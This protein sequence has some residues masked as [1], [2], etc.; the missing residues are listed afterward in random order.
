M[1]SALLMELSVVI[2]NGN[3]LFVLLDNDM[4]IV[5]PVY[6]F[7]KF[8]KQKDK[9]I[10]TIKAN[11]S[12]LKIYW[13]FLNKNGY[14]FNEVTPSTV[15]DFIEYLRESDDSE[16]VVALHKE[17][18][19]T[20]KTINRILSTVYSFYKYCGMMQEINNPI[21][22]EEINRPFNM[23][24]SL[25]H[26]ARNDN[27]IKQS[28]FKVKESKH[29]VRLVCDHEAETFLNALPTWR[30]KLIFKVLY[31]TGARI[32]E[33]LDLQIEIIPYPDSSKQLGMLEN[34]KSKGKRRNLYIPMAL[35][36]EL[37]KFIV[38]KRSNI[39]TEHSYIFVAQQKQNLGKPLTYRGIYEVF[40][41][42]KRKTGI[43]FN[44]HDLRHTYITH[45]VENG[46]DISV[47]RIIAGHEN[48][49]TTQQYTHISDKYLE[50]SLSKYWQSSS[51][52]GGNY[53]EE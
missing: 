1:G 42:V 35:I 4:K 5:K 18:K 51:L 21:M 45:L 24:K 10:N 32:Q 49:A 48:V 17:S 11:G 52:M 27:K 40:D 6:N 39:D 25:L 19:R 41:A 36:E 37:D 30:D 53:N 29:N 50:D 8:Q 26:H 3:K 33:A 20:S 9:A 43:S 31:L 34:I 22:M 12:D 2:N 7:L 47:V 46:M 15:A 13:D 38:E 44:F 16:N 28:L 23:F 14:I